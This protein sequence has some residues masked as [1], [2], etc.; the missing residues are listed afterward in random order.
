MK[1]GQ[2]W[3]KLKPVENSKG[4][5][6]RRWK[7]VK[8]CT[9]WTQKTF[10]PFPQIKLS[11]FLSVFGQTLKKKVPAGPSLWQTVFG[12]LWLP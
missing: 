11:G 6:T 1:L 10:S 5:K 9:S 12:G 8:V 7:C 4:S 3:Q 2:L